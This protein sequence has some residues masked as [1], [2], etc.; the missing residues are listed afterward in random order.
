MVYFSQLPAVKTDKMFWSLLFRDGFDNDWDEKKDHGSSLQAF[1]W[2][3]KMDINS[4][5][6]INYLPN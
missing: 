1:L 3:C 5:A 6:F 4:E 2:A